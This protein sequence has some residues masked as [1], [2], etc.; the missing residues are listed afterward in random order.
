MEVN[1]QTSYWWQY[2]KHSLRYAGGIRMIKN[3]IVVIDSGLSHKYIEN[4]S[5]KLYIGK[6]FFDENCNVIEDKIGHGT[7]IINIT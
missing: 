5:I 7:S 6:N 2:R 3:K 1:F 4:C